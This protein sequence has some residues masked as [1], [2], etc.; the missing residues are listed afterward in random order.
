MSKYIF[1]TTSHFKR[2]KRYTKFFLK[3]PKTTKLEK[4]ILIVKLFHFPHQ[5]FLKSSKKIHSSFNFPNLDSHPA[6]FS[7]LLAPRNHLIIDRTRKIPLTT[8]PSFLSIFFPPQ[9]E[10][11]RKQRFSWRRINKQK[12]LTYFQFVVARLCSRKIKKNASFS[13]VGLFRIAPHQLNRFPYD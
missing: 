13:F 5:Y 1:C 4:L 11:K 6:H 7:N 10:I 2:T 8:R 12:Q 3:P 9:R